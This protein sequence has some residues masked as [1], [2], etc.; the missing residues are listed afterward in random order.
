METDMETA[1]GVFPPAAPALIPVL[2]VDLKTHRW[3]GNMEI[4]IRDMRPAR[5]LKETQELAVV[6]TQ[7][8]YVLGCMLDRIKYG[9]KDNQAGYAQYASFGAYVESELDVGLAQADNFISAYRALRNNNIPFD[10]VADLLPS[11]VM[12]IAPVL[13]PETVDEQVKEF[14][15]KTVKEV[16]TIVATLKKK[17]PKKVAAG[18]KAAAAK[19]AKAESIVTVNI[20]GL[21]ETITDEQLIELFQKLPIA[22]L[23]KT[24]NASKKKGIKLQATKTLAAKKATMAAIGMPAE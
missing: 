22:R 21:A 23:I 5:L 4:A 13:K 3:T 2:D 11:V 7:S 9:I 10:K 17:D 12:L 24:F 14:A 15:N 20:V 6:W 19:K 1:D 16:K 8:W 18:L